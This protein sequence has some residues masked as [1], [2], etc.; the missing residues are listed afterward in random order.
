MVK[1]SS[2]KE[3]VEKTQEK[4]VK[5]IKFKLPKITIWQATTLVLVVLLVGIWTK[6]CPTGKVTAIPSEEIGQKAIDFINNNLVSP[7]TSASLVSVEDKESYYVVTTNYRGQNI[8]VYV[9]KD[10]KYMFLSQPL[11]MTQE[12]P[13]QEEEEKETSSCED[14]PKSD[15]PKL[16]AFVMSYC[17]FGL[18][19]QR[20]LNEI[21]KNIP[22][23]ANYI[24][25]RYIGS[26]ADN[27]IQSMHGEKEGVEDLRQICIREEQSDK[28]WKYI[29]CFIKEGKSEECLDEVG[30]DKPELE[31][32]MND[33]T[34]G[35]KYA[36]EDFD[37]NEQYHISGS[38]TLVLNGERVNEYDFGG[39]SAEA[40][41]TIICCGFEQ[42]PEFCQQN[43]TTEQAARAF[44]P[45]YSAN[46]GSSGGQC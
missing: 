22:E 16:I 11:D 32:C 44:S 26:I 17:P 18:Q 33:T 3:K 8:P 2:K 4:E 1:K 42:Q 36:Q 43:L 38:P 6:G 45:T 9:T 13:K 25:V 35:L 15:N 20:V 14:L 29:D 41:K 24:E 27:K 7:G 21:V 5:T 10:G 23:M 19:M 40:V 37:L 12:I 39:R 28:Y 34:R 30:I 31:A 46:S